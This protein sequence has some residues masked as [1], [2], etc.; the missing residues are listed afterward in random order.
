MRHTKLHIVRDSSHL[1]LL[2][3]SEDTGDGLI[4]SGIPFCVGH[5][6]VESLAKGTREGSNHAILLVEDSVGLVPGVSSGKSDDTDAVFVV[7]NVLVEVDLGGERELDHDGL[8]W[9][10]LGVEALNELCLEDGFD[11]CLVGRVDINF[12]L[13]DGDKSV[14]EDLVTNLE[15]LVDDSLDPFFVEF[16]DVR[17][18]LGSEDSLGLC[19]L[20]QSI[21]TWVG[22]HDLNS[23]FEGS[24]SLVALQEGDDLFLFPKEGRGRDSVDLAI[25]GVLEKNGTKSTVSLKTRRLDN[26]G[27]NLVDDVEH[28]DFTQ[29]VLILFDSEGLE[30]LWSGSSRLIEGSKVAIEGLG[31][32]KLFS[33][34]SVA[35][36]VLVFLIGN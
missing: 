15:L 29:D 21:E 9:G 2:G 26:A 13:E 11:L 19:T 16:L 18:H 3:S 27:S 17:S 36:F 34:N 25:H 5:L 12:R 7:N 31:T 20:Q 24:E 30:G 22:L 10:D 32:F 1:F 33:K 6:V 28:G 8:S 14:G 4:E 23:V 35:H